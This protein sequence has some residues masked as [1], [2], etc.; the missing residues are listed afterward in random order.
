MQSSFLFFL[1]MVLK[2]AEIS[3]IQLRDYICYSKL[4][5]ALKEMCAALK[6]IALDYG[7]SSYE[8]FGRAFQGVCRKE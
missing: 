2:L 1:I 8:A 6:E 5:V 4:T 7:L 3:G